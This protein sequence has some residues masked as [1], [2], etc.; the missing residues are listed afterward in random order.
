MVTSLQQSQ[1]LV[2]NGLPAYTADAAW[3]CLKL[4]DKEICTFISTNPRRHDKI[5]PA[6]SLNKLISILP[7]ELNL[8]GFKFNFHLIKD[9][10]NGYNACY[11]Y[12]DSLGTQEAYTNIGKTPLDA[13]YKLVNTLL[14]QKLLFSSPFKGEL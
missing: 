1:I 2:H 7:H 5:F 8:N 6:W 13:V 14:R 12:I 4:L 10:P 3:C 9:I 11:Y